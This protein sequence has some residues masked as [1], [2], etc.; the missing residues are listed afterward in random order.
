M[1]A[2]C[3]RN[4]AR[5]G[6]ADGRRSPGSEPQGEPESQP[7]PTEDEPNR[8][9]RL[10]KAIGPGV[11]TGA[12]DDDPSGIA[13]YAS[14]G[15]SLG[16]ATLWTAPVTFPLMATVQYIC[17]KIGMVSG[18]GLAGVLRKHYGRTL[19]YPAVLLLVIANTVNAGTDI[20]AIAAG[21][22]LLLPA[23][24]IWMLIAPIAAAILALQIWGSYRL[25]ANTFRWLTLALLAYIAAGFLARPDWGEALRGTVT[26]NIAFNSTYITALIAILG[27][28]ISPYLF[29]W[30]ASEEVEEEVSMG[31][32]QLW[33]REGASSTEMKY[34]ACDVNIGMLF[35]NIVFYFVILASAATLN[36]AGQYEINSAADAAQALRPLAGDLAGLLF[37]VGII[38]AGVLAVPVLTGSAAYAV[39][40]AF[41]WKSGL[42]EKPWKARQF[43]GVIVV[44]TLFGVAIDFLGIN[45]MQ[46]LFWTAVI[47]GVLA[48]PLLVLIML[49][50]NNRSIMGERVNNVWTNIVGW[51]ATATMLVAA[52]GLFLTWGT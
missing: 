11:I 27:T 29:F 3:P 46:A 45:P 32:T 12:S 40:E 24:P 47:N 37:A 16:Y 28:T 1:T 36:K 23:I 26:P 14:V 48:G 20:A 5:N 42:E 33:E 38:G 2:Q 17:A 25:I 21:I 34:A 18:T 43:Y 44:A 35:A 39:S 31:R 7:S 22:N 52:V 51:T 50:A 13:T 41:G 4:A 15:A 9:K 10:L 30:Q 8:F 6:Q 49:I 19:L